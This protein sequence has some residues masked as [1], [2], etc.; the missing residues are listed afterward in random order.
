[1]V[2]SDKN[3]NLIQPF[4]ELNTKLGTSDICRIFSATG[5]G[6][7]NK[8]IFTEKGEEDIYI[9]SDYLSVDND[10]PFG[11]STCSAGKKEIFIGADGMLYPCP[12]YMSDD[13][14]IGNVLESDTIE[15]LLKN[16]PAQYVSE[17]II[18]S[19]PQ[20]ISKCKEC[21]VQLFC[22][23]CPGEIRDIKTESAF[24]KR[25][26]L[27]KPILMERVWEKSINY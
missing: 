20:N 10:E 27:V 14:S 8:S 6:I 13:F 7:E 19:H 4:K 17:F 9:P 15:E 23:T 5:R 11:I 12:S 22:W 18:K 16:D 2:F 1:M 24:D 21:K 25:C 3:E 26:K